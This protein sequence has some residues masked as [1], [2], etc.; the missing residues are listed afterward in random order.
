MHVTQEGPDGLSPYCLV[1]AIGFGEIHPFLLSDLRGQDINKAPSGSSS[2]VVGGVD[3]HKDLHFAG[4]VD[5]HDRVLGHDC[6]PTTRHGYKAMLGWM[7]SFGELARVGIEC[8]GSY[9][10]GL[11]RYLQNAGVEV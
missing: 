5:T 7:R 3:T 4:V 9:G 10:A 8:T 11:L 2:T 6:F 1:H